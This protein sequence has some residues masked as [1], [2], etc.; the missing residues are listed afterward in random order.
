MTVELQGGGGVC[1][2]LSVLTALGQQESPEAQKPE[3]GSLAQGI[4]SSERC[5]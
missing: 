2:G 5:G 3:L 1:R 4:L